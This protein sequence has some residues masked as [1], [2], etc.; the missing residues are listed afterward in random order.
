M[1]FAIELTSHTRIDLDF[2]FKRFLKP[3][4]I[5]NVP[6]VHPALAFI[7]LDAPAVPAGGLTF[8]HREPLT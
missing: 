3:D 4:R 8:D 1:I 7:Y 5:G 2:H 6:T